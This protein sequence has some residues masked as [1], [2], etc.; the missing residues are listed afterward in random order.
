MLFR[1][2]QQIGRATRK[3]PATDKSRSFI[4]DYT[5]ELDSVA[6]V[7]VPSRTELLRRL[8]QKQHG[9]T[10]SEVM[11]ESFGREGKSLTMADWKK[12]HIHWAAPQTCK[13]EALCETQLYASLAQASGYKSTAHM[14]RALAKDAIFITTEKNPHRF[15]N[16][17][18]SIIGRLDALEKSPT[19]EDQLIVQLLYNKIRIDVTQLPD[20]MKGQPVMVFSVNQRII[21]AQNGRNAYGPNGIRKTGHAP[22]KTSKSVFATVS[23]YLDDIPACLPTTDGNIRAL[24]AM[25]TPVVSQLFVQEL[26][27]NMRKQKLETL[28][29]LRACNPQVREL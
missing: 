26:L 24:Y 23:K 8:A 29:P 12:H 19:P 22:V 2:I 17:W 13:D 20:R 4:Y 21:G 25:I 14:F 27:P 10:L 28:P 9:T 15:Q 6:H 5:A 1:S 16:R 18:S 7:H 3:S 11:I